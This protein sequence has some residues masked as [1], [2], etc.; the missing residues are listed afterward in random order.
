MAA[1]CLCCC[2]QAFSTCGASASHCGGFS[3]WRAQDLE[4]TG[5]VVAA[6]R[7]SCP[8]AWGIFPDQGSNPRPCIGRQILSHWTTREDCQLKILFSTYSLREREWLPT[9]VFLSGEFQDRGAWWAIHPWGWEQNHSLGFPR[10][11]DGKESTCSAGDLGS[12]S[13]SGS[14]LGESNGYPFQYSCLENPMDR[15][16][17]Q[18]TVHGVAKSWRQLSD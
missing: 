15:G 4:Y 1:L 12:I 13:G 2:M 17:W 11:S 14:S 9:P 5:S 8:E 18:A 3:Y 10:G 6:H 7:F 16:D